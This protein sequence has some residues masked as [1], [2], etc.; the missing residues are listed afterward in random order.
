MGANELFQ[1]LL[2]VGIVGGLGFIIYTSIKNQNLSDTWQEIKDL[3]IIKDG[4]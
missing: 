1:N 4:I 2:A 3:F